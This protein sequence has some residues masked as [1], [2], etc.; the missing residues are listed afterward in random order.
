MPRTPKDEAWHL[1][2]QL[3]PHDIRK[4]VRYLF[5][6]RSQLL[7]WTAG[8]LAYL[9][10]LGFAA[11]VTPGV[12]KN[13]LARHVAREVETERQQ[14]TERLRRL[15]ER[16]GDLQ[17]QSDDL[18]LKMGKIFLVYGLTGQESI[19]QGG[20]PLSAE[21]VPV[22]VVDAALREEIGKGNS[23]TA[24]ID[25]QLR[26]LE[27]FIGEVQEFEKAYRDQ[28]LTTPSLCPLRGSDF[29]LTS[30]FGN[31][32]NP[33][34]KQRDFHNGI[35]LAAPVGTPIYAPADGLVVFAGRF[36]SRRSLAW[37]RYGNLVILMHGERFISLY[38]H[39]QDIA[40]RNRQRLRQGDLVGTVGNTGWSTNPHLHYE[41][42]RR[43]EDGVWIPLDP[44]IYILD[45]RWRDEEKLLVLA[46]SAPESDDFEPLPQII[47]R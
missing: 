1:E 22:S 8:A 42:R 33:F 7:G 16:L 40:V 9:V 41:V 23:L 35:D 13:L 46:R 30:P 45:H 34:T 29:V 27:T 20:Y 15:T 44:R 5:L 19:G 2:I 11:A 10:F 18:R 6:T 25:E 4:G 31:R 36:S 3:H 21:P 12:V 38:G 17:R 37:S 32:R 39:C 14:Q 24:H 28:V 43:R 26:V 47:A